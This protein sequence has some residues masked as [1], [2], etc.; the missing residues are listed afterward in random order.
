[1]KKRE[2]HRRKILRRVT[3]IVLALSLGSFSLPREYFDP[4][5]GIDFDIFC[6][7]S[8]YINADEREIH[9]KVLITDEEIS[10]ECE[11]IA[12]VLTGVFIHRDFFI[13]PPPAVLA[14]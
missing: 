9:T 13:R 1:M 3:I 14:A 6:Q 2:R 11:E 7:L 12:L 8:S 4:H 10:E 5:L